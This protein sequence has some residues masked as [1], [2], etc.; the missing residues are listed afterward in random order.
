MI[1]ENSWIKSEQ[2][3]GVNLI[4]VGSG[5]ISVGGGSSD[6]EMTGGLVWH[7]TSSGNGA[8][9]LLITF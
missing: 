5:A 3:W 7:G 1:Y 9:K 6:N 8:I 4:E 2:D